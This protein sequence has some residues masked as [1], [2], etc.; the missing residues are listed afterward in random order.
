MAI[1]SECN[2]LH[3]AGMVFMTGLL[4]KAIELSSFNLKK[5]CQVFSTPCI[6]YSATNSIP[7]LSVKNAI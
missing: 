1:D 5:P 2:V 3:G 4:T 7:S 6:Q